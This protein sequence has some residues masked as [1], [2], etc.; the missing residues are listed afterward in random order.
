MEQS[1][2]ER[3]AELRSQIKALKDSM[4]SGIFSISHRG[5]TLT[6]RNITEMQKVLNMAQD[7]LN[8]LLGTS[9]GIFVRGGFSR[10]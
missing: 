5:K 6:Y 8:G 2:K 9:K 10:D 1:K 4:A 7:E 3:I